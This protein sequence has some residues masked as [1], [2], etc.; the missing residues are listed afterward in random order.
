MRKVWGI[1]RA[2]EG[3]ITQ[4]NACFILYDTHFQRSSWGWGFWEGELN[5]ELG[6]TSSQGTFFVTA[7]F[8]SYASR[9]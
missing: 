5:T 8:S 4:L 3:S 7:A 9:I 2:K 1:A 6:S